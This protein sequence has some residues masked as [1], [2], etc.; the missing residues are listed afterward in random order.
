MTDGMVHR[1]I[2]IRTLLSSS[3]MAAKV[4]G[5]ESWGV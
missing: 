3:A 1:G 5:L 2:K 4:P